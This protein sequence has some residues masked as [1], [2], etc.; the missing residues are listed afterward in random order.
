[1]PRVMILAGKSTLW[2][3]VSEVLQKAEQ[4]DLV[5]WE[6]ELDQAL[7]R[8]RELRPDVVLVDKGSATA[9]D[10]PLIM[11]IL[12][13]GLGTRVFALSLEDSSLSIYREERLTVEE[14]EDL[15]RAIEKDPTASRISVSPAS[16][17]RPRQ[18]G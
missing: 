5:C 14:G 10:I 15:I 12:G 17:L 16:C 2:W 6:T 1:M 18:R 9:S 3:G 13:E 4:C 11:G 7:Q 8:I